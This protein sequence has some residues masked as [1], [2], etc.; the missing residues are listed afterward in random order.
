MCRLLMKYPDIKHV[1][2]GQGNHIDID[3]LKV[4]PSLIVKVK[5]DTMMSESTIAQFKKWIKVRLQTDNI[6]IEH[7]SAE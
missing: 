6:E 5:S 7:S 1:Y 3:S 4:S 2:I